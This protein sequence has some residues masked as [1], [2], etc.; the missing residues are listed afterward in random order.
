[1]AL[2]VHGWM[3]SCDEQV[4]AVQHHLTQN[5]LQV[6]K[7]TKAGLAGY[8]PGLPLVSFDQWTEHFH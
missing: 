6:P 1:M 3:A 5:A 4:R 8:L 7:A 2:N